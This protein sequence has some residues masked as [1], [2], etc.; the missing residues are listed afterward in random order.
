[1]RQ[2]RT[3]IRIAWMLILI[4][5]S[6][7]ITGCIQ[8]PFKITESYD[9]YYEKQEKNET[10]DLQG[11]AKD[12]AVLSADE[13]NTP[14]YKSSDY[15]DLLI[16]D[17][18]NEVI[19]S[20]RCFERVY[21]ASVTKIMTALIVLENG[22]L[23]DEV[24]LDHDIDLGEDG[25]VASTL[26]KGDTVSVDDLFHGLLVKSANDC[27]VILA[28][29]IAGSEEAFV[30]MMNE[31]A[32]ELGATHTHFANSHGLHNDNHYTT[33]Y[34]LYL[35]FKEV[36]KYD[37]FLDTASLKDYT[38]TY[39]TADGREVSEY[40][41]STDEFLLNTYPVPDGV[42]LYGGKTGTTSMA[43]SCLILM[44]ENEA[45]ERFFSV[46]MGAETHE[47]LYSSMTELLEN[48]VND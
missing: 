8:N 13:Q 48:I 3:C 19:K 12:L 45:G 30:D 17:S 16:N 46:V 29:Y 35:I 38:M 18:T 6:V 9:S 21:P 23:D 36:V 28:E 42:T 22:N 15:A 37:T 40:M 5:L 33:A 32:K 31:R 10:Q 24:T 11:M 26:S 25:A 34:D 44:T 20:Y 47:D 2:K 43:K 7:S 39:V 41:Q 1:M 14:G 27:A 4:M